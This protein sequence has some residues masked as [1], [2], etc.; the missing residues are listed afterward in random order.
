MTEII[1]VCVGWWCILIAPN[2]IV[3]TAMTAARTRHITA[4]N[5]I[6][7]DLISSYFY[8]SYIGTVMNE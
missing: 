7:I 8:Y 4:D 6:L 5:R 3:S 1:C 2:N